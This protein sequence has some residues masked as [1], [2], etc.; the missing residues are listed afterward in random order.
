MTDIDALTLDAN[1]VALYAGDPNVEIVDAA[2]DYNAEHGQNPE[3][4]D[5]DDER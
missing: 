5:E 4:I 2:L 1:M 3:L